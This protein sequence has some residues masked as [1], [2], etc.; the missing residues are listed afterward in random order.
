M[1]FDGIKKFYLEKIEY[2]D[3]FYLDNIKVL[4]LDDMFI[5][6]FFLEVRSLNFIMRNM[7]F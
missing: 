1:Y 2:I 3:Y 4:K 6:L 5:R 7:F